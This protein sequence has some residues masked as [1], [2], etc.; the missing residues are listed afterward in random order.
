[1]GQNPKCS[2]Y[3]QRLFISKISKHCLMG[4]SSW[5]TG[6]KLKLNP[7]KTYFFLIVTKLQREKFL[8]NFPCLI[9]GQDTNPTASAKN[10]GVVFDSSPNGRKHIYPKHVGHVNSIIS[11]TF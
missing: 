7:S 6:S 8:H 5:M 11:V 10:L 1:M 3:N 9:L 4:L 2:G